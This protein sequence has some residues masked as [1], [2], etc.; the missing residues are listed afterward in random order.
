M[1][2]LVDIGNT[3]I[4]WTIANDGVL[5]GQDA[6][7]HDLSS[8]SSKNSAGRLTV[9]D[10]Q[11]ADFE[12]PE[13]VVIANGAGPTLARHIEFW[14]K[15]HWLCPISYIT[16]PKAGCGVVNAY[17]RHQ[18]LGI[19]RW[20]NLLASHHKIDG[21]V[22]VIDCGTAITVDA[23]K[24]N[25]EHLGGCILPGLAMMRATLNQTGKIEIDDYDNNDLSSVNASTKSAVYCGTLYA[26]IKAIDAIVS[27]MKKELGDDVSCVITGGDAEQIL[28]LLQQPTC[29]EQD[30]VFQG[31]L[32]SVNQ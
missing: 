17:E 13:R 9:L 1:M 16:T 21:N 31:M 29:Y 5:S 26:A 24:S 6:L 28:A 18:D 32:I 23:I 11:W 2:L 20:L 19:D 12:T 27:D 30:W 10:Q 14:V 3:R 22:C 4:K 25:G 8:M 7:L 15:Q